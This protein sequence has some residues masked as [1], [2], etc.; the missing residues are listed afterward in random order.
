MIKAIALDDEPL[1]LDVIRAFCDRTDIVELVKTFTGPTEAMKYMRKH[2]V[3]LLFLDVRMPAMSGIDFY[4]A[5]GQSTMVIFTTA[6]SEYAVEGFNL[7]AVDYLLKPIQFD[8]FMQ[9]VNKATEYDNFLHNKETGE[10]RYLFLRIDYSLVK[11]SID[12]IVYVESMDN[13]LKIHTRNGKPL[14]VRMSMKAIAD[15]LP[16]QKFMRVHRSYIV[17]VNDIVSIRNKNIQIGEVK[18][19]VGINYEAAVEQLTGKG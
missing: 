1:A 9:A 17:S 13:Y 5:V 18:I 6:Y 15:K 12:D 16:E 19:P 4:K 11:L 7:S 10:E 8:R 14:L 2:P 3:D